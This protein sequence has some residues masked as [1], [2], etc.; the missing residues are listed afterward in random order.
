[1][2]TRSNGKAIAATVANSIG[3]AV[4]VD[5]DGKLMLAGAADPAGGSALLARYIGVEIA[6]NVIEFYNSGLDHYFITADAA[7][8]AAVDGGAAGLGWVR[9][10]HTWKSGGPDRVCRFYGSPE[11]NPATGLRRG[12]N[13]HFYTISADECEAVKQDP[14]W[15]FESYDFSG[16][17]KVIDGSCP[18]GT[19]AVKRVYNGRFAQNDSNHRYTTDDGVY[20]QM[21][22]AGWTGEGSVFCAVL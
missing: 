10:G 5:P 20:N 7:E 22:T 18:V 2:S 19:V 1:M 3:Y 11:I 9:T 6:S 12:P 8:A 16:W 13:S 14:G 21:V 17:P 4:S 15:R